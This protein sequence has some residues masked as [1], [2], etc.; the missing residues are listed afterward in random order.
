M[1]TP[2]KTVNKVPRRVGGLKQAA[3][4]EKVEM[5]KIVG[6]NPE[7][8]QHLMHDVHVFIGKHPLVTGGKSQRRLHV[9]SNGT[10]PTKIF[11]GVI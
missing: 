5:L 8:H 11:D 3:I 10:V 9:T 7:D 6:G 4:Y 2:L 1:R